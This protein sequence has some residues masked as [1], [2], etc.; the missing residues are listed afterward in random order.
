MRHG[1]KERYGDNKRTRER[2]SVVVSWVV[3]LVK[4]VSTK[5]I[6][7]DD[8]DDDVDDGHYDDDDDYDNKLQHRRLLKSVKLEHDLLIL[9]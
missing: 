7:T 3:L 8:D 4:C 5:T 2:K 1:Q 6:G 9:N